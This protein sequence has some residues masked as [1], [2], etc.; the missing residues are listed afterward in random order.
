MSALLQKYGVG[1]DEIVAKAGKLSD[2]D[3]QAGIG[4]NPDAAM[5]I[6]SEVLLEK[7]DHPGALYGVGIILR[8]AGRWSQAIQIA[9]RVTEVRPKDPR[10]WKLLATI[11]GALC[12]YDE[13][14]PY[15]EKAVQ[16]LRTDH[17]VADYAYALSNAGEYERAYRLCLEAFELATTNPSGLEGEAVR[18]ARVTIAHCELAQGMWEEG[19]RSFR[20]TMRT[21]WRKE[22]TYGDSK[23]WMG[24]PD[25]VVM[26]TGEQG[27]GDEVMAAS[28]VPDAAKGCKRFI[29][30]CDARLATLFARS[31]P[32]QITPTRRDQSIVLPPGS[33][34]PT[35]HKSL[36]GLGELFRK[37][38]EDFP[39]KPFLIPNQEYIGMFRE[40]FG[41]QKTIGLAWSGGL[42]R[43]GR[44]PRAAGLNAFLPIL[45]R[46]GQFVSLQYTDDSAE[47][48]EL[49]QQGIRVRSFPWVTRGP[50]M[51]LLAGLLAAC[52]EVI[53]VHT[54]ALHLSSAMGVPTT[55]LVHRGS[56]WRYAQKELI[57]YPKTT[58]L[59]HKRKG[60]SWRDCVERLVNERSNE[61]SDQGAGD[62]ARDGGEAGAAVRLPSGAT[63]R[64]A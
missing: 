39:R 2:G 18:N 32:V 47:I 41:G 5:E 42:P 59:W 40:L 63:A 31:F 44:E 23:E 34:L 48:R 52:D 7:P 21:K 35:H 33:E 62:H 30:D 43:T 24:E 61:R 1:V 17:T 45:K 11:Y 57:W 38:D 28:M 53:G 20:S 8:E 25:A 37:R 29:F 3:P 15:A 12:R 19:F 55:T 27:L 56:G 51:D 58:R 36:F 50:D 22:W 9:K 54:T 6:Y 4:E 46:G 14:L 49:A 13:S 10:G 16:C 60:E 64:V 26:V